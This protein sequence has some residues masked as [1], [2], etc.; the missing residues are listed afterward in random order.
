MDNKSAGFTLFFL[1]INV[2]GRLHTIFCIS[3]DVADFSIDLAFNE[4][5]NE[6]GAA[7]K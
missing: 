1:I 7:V 2:F 6:G 5:S 4:R 3:F